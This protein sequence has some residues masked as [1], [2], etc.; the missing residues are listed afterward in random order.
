[1]YEIIEQHQL[2]LIF[3]MIVSCFCGIAIGFERK[4]RAKEAGV[5]THCIVACASAMMM[6]ISKYAFGDLLD[7]DT[8]ADVRLDP[9]RMAQGIVTGVGFLG[10]GIIYVQRS[11]IRGLTTA[12][13][14]WATSGIGM[15]IGSGMYMIGFSGTLIILAA[16]LILHTSS[17][18]MVS[19][20]CKFIKVYGI[21]TPDFQDDT[22][23]LLKCLHVTV[24][25]V[26]VVRHSNGLYD[27]TFYCEMPADVSEEKI[28]T[29]FK[30]KCTIDTTR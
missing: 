17:K 29:R 16:Q 18:F 19:H 3:R 8:A 12:A 2:N 21:E 27:Y 24:N 22:T 1:M 28:I 23:D 15:A 5:R 10:A 20:K 11:N 13:G 30:N 14:L 9:S 6:I 25:E 4:N 7:T 26:S